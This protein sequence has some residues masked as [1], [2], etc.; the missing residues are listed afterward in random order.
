MHDVIDEPG[1]CVHI[2][3][4]FSAH[5]VGAQVPPLLPLPLPLPP[6][7]PPLQMT[8]PVMPKQIGDPEAKQQLT[9]NPPPTSSLHDCAE[10]GYPAHAPAAPVAHVGDVHV[11]PL[12]LPP[13]LLPP[14]LLPLLLLPP[15]LLLPLL[16]PHTAP[17][18]RV[19]HAAAPL[20]LLLELVTAGAQRAN[21]PTV[22]VVP[23]TVCADVFCAYPGRSCHAPP[24]YIAA[25]SADG[26]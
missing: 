25:R 10:P 3:A 7:L 16:L 1:Y 15:P 11:V 6:L 17:K 14:L 21:V 24:T 22:V 19:A 20:L 8:P 9:V 26:D 18:S 5:V 12:L 23:E 4:A 2:D 13:V